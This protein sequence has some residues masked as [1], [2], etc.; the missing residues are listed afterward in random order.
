MISLSC[1]KRRPS[2]IELDEGKR[3]VVVVEVKGG[4]QLPFYFYYWLVTPGVRTD[5]QKLEAISTYRD[6]I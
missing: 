3:G 5:Q 6:H 4:K 2:T 1:H